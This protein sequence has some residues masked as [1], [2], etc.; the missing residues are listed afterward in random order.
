MVCLCGGDTFP[1]ESEGE[2]GGKCLVVDLLQDS[3]LGVL[4][5]SFFL[6]ITRYFFL[7]ALDLETKFNMSLIHKTYKGS[8][9][10]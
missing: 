4:I 6:P 2:S 7:P 9:S 5:L 8:K 3:G 10:G 1:G